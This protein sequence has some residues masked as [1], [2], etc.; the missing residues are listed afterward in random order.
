MRTILAAVIVAAGIGV[1]SV[2]SASATPASG[3]A[4]AGASQHTDLVIDVAGGC[5][6]HHHRNR[7]GHCVPD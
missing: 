1:V 6:R 3:S 4:V 5:G 7:H 2:Y